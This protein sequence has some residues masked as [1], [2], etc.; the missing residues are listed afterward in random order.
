MI[1]SNGM[2]SLC[3]VIVDISIFLEY[4]RANIIDPDASIELL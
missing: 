2:R 3:K 1:S 4:P